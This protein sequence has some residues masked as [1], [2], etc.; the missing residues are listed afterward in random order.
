MR[1]ILIAIGY[2]WC[3]LCSL[4]MVSIW[5]EVMW[6]WMGVIGVILGMTLFL[7]GFIIFPFVFWLVEGAFPT[8]YFFLWLSLFA[9]GQLLRL[10]KD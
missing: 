7:P 9:A 6:G 8:G 4:T 5:V 3:I 2:L 10:S 1:G